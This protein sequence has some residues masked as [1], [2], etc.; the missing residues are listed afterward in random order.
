MLIM[1]HF[2]SDFINM[3]RL[4]FEQPFVSVIIPVYNDRKRLIL[5]LN[6]LEKQ[7]YPKDLYEV[8]I[9]D[10]GS[11]EDISDL[12]KQ[13]SNVFIFTEDTP[14][15]YA[16]RNKGIAKAK[17]SIFAFTDADCIPKFNW[18]E[19]GVEKFLQTPNCGLVGGKID[20][21]FKNLSEPT[22][23]EIYESIEMDFPQETLLAEQRYA[24]TANV[25]TSKQVIDNVK[26]FNNKLKS[27]GDREWGQRVFNAGY[28]Q[29]FA[30]EA[31]VE[32]PARYSIWQLYKRITRINGGNF[33]ALKDNISFKENITALGKDLRLAF[34]PPL[35]SLLK[36]WTQEKRL[37]TNKQRLQFILVMLFV[38]YV[39]A[40]ERIRLRLGGSS[41]RW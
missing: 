38:R 9:I 39:S 16:A 30:Q 22:A 8:I 25:F 2:N 23:V 4:D 5:C 34:T 33:D 37:S 32:H 13:S 18:I 35:R 15:S 6:V 40:W 27:G 14:G 17:G 29:V 36:I 20:L 3:H 10:N 26:T 11:D 12:S 7:S 24:L 41:R 28:E 21:F 1:N 31:C 19:K